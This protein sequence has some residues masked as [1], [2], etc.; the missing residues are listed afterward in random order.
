MATGSAGREHDAAHR[1][2][3][4]VSATGKDAATVF[5]RK[6]QF[7]VGAPVSFDEVYERVSSLEYVLGA[8]GAELVNGFLSLARRRR[9]TIDHAE[10]V[11][12]GEMSSPLFYLGVVGATGH[13][14]LECVTIKVYVSALED[15]SD[16]RRVWEELLERSPLVCTLRPVVRFDLGL[17][18]SL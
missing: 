2:T 1:F 14:G 9:L 5:V 18:V 16:V 8:I 13:A 10:A 3:V 12:H 15:D 7:V 17:K 6:H 11:V 4:R